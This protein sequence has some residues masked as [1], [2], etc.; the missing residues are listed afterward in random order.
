MKELAKAGIH[1]DFVTKEIFHE[2]A[3]F[4]WWCVG[5]YLYRLYL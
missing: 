5:M 1:G 2:S 3:D 4:G